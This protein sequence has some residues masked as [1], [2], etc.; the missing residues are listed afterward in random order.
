LECVG[1]YRATNVHKVPRTDE[2]L[3]NAKSRTN[4]RYITLDTADS[5][6]HFFYT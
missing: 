5:L 4:I 3:L 1:V 6:A 2:Q